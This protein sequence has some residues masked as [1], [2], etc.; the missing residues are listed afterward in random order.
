MK[1]VLIFIFCLSINVFT[2]V[3][4]ELRAVWIT[5]V[6][7][8]VLFSDKNIEDAMTFLA[9]RGFNLVFPVVWNKGYTLYPSRVMDSIFQKPIWPTFAGRDP[10]KKIVL[11]AHKH[12]MEVV[13]WFEFGFA[14]SYSLNGGHLIAGKPSWALKNSAGSLVVKNGFDW[15]SGIN[16]EVQDFMIALHNEVIDNYDV[17]GVQ[18]DD[19]LPAM[20][21]E[22]GYD[23]A[24]VAVYKS[25]NNN[26]NPPANYYDLGWKRWRANK[27]SQFYRRLKDSVKVR[28]DYLL[29]SSAPSVYPW[30]FDN[31][32]QDSKT[33]VDSGIAENFIPQLYRDSYFGYVNEFNNSYNQVTPSKRNIFYAGVLAKAGSF[34]IPADYLV[35]AVN[36]NRQ[37]NV[38]GECF[39]FYE[40]FTANNN[41]LG[42]TIKNRFY[43]EPA[44]LPYRNGTIFR[45]KAEIVNEDDSLL[46]RRTGNWIKVPV[47]GYNPNLYWTNDTSLST[48]EWY[49][50]IDFDAWFDVYVYLIPNFAFSSTA[51]YTIYS[52]NDSSSVVLNLR[53]NANTNWVK[54]GSVY[55]TKGRRKVIKI[56]NS[57]PEA[58]KY[59]I[60]DAAMA[61]INRKKSPDVVITSVEREEENFTGDRAGR[62]LKQSFPNP[63]SISSPF[64]SIPYS[65]GGISTVRMEIFNLLG[66]L[67]YEKNLGEKPAGEYVETVDLSS[68]GNISSGI[69]FYRIS[70]D[71]KRE[72]GKLLL[73]K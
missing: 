3:K 27:L 49:M 52:Q 64:V 32:L 65:L 21:I 18:G 14:S 28:G 62:M 39:F 31:Y 17:D 58:G 7:S 56:D 33:W 11:E 55:Q 50:D 63:V 51:K 46:T 43:S 73:T 24:T 36:Y 72:T 25:E 35:S 20:P 10:L 54:L 22:G 12:G 68:A 16:P 47:Q 9:N 44:L 6:D 41:A 70:T 61:L 4:Q 71:Y 23:S 59:I 67:I 34:L 69:Y 30:G 57:M 29:I 40:A 60:A 1:Y 48:F 66:E 19:R 8:Y 45:P 13:P 2:Q 26:N 53:D 42:D 15:M 37:Q 5:N 38:K